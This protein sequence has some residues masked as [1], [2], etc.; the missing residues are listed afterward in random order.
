MA[1][2]ERDIQHR[3]VRNTRCTNRL[4]KQFSLEL[5]H[6]D[7]DSNY[8]DKYHWMPRDRS[9]IYVAYITHDPHCH[10]P[11]KNRDCDGHV[12]TKYDDLTFLQH[13]GRDTD[14]EAILDDFVAIYARLK[15][16]DLDGFTCDTNIL[17]D[18]W[19]EAAKQGKVGTP[20]AVPI[21][22][23]Y[24]GG[25]REVPWD[26]DRKLDAVWI[27]DKELIEELDTVKI[28]ERIQY[29]HNRFES[30]I[31]TYNKWAEGDCWGV[32]VDE[33]TRIGPNEYERTENDSCWGFIGSDYALEEALSNLLYNR[34]YFLANRVKKEHD[35]ANE[36]TDP[37]G[38]DDR[39]HLGAA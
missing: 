16:E 13:V 18:M 6:N 5:E 22:A 28:D 2:R 29:A 31:D 12:V 25:F 1:R 7:G 37:A 32:T 9:I 15:G 35:H 3:I 30:A 26:D 11:L 4:I 19:E 34:K 33:F 39:Q 23:L 8:F 24:N 14:G 36:K 10:D 21:E 17:K 20:Y 27:P 38:E